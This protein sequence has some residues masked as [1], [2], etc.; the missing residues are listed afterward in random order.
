MFDWNFPYPSRRAPVLARNV[1]ATSQ[2]LAA[3]AGLEMLRRGGNAVDAAVATAIA[4]TVVEPC[5]NGLGGDAFAIVAEPGGELIGLNA[6]GRSPAAWTIERF[7]GADAMPRFGWDAVTVPGAVSGWAALWRR[8]GRLPFESLFEPAV[9][10]AEEGFPVGHVTA[11]AWARAADTYAEFA[12]FAAHFLPGG[13]A[14]AAGETFKSPATGATLRRIAETEGE[15]FYRGDLAERIH[16]AAIAEGGALRAADLAAH[17]PTWVRPIAQPY[18]GVELVELPPNGQGLAAQ[19]ALA[20]LGR[21]DAARFAPGGADWTHLLV[22]AMKVA[23]RAAFDHFADPRAMRLAPEALL[24][25]GAI[26]RAAAAIG[27]VAAPLP[28]ALLPAGEDTVY[29][30]AA[31]QDGWMVSMIQSNYMGFGSGVVIPGTGIAMQNRGAGFVLDA[32]HPNCAGPA[33]RPFHTIIP[34]F[35]SQG[36]VPLLAF[37]VMGGHMQHQG[38]VQMVTRIFDHGENPQA[39]CDAPRWHVAP[40]FSVTLEAGYAPGVADELARRGHRVSMAAG[41][42]PFGGAQLVHRLPQGGWCAAS[43]HRKE[44][45]AAG[46]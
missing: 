16:A 26:A 41:P 43:D 32:A 3:S 33:K 46:F 4:L 25:P 36:G 8:F 37:G 30:A 6:S 2:P 15:A 10:Y 40:D 23:I 18:R 1:V 20:I 35:V 27:E 19:I 38:H 17:E 5:S 24:A 21:L 34:G 12:E 22:E 14:P 11:A 13:K 31:D 9:R 28:A 44:G 39:A 7:A 42:A 45:C 29:L